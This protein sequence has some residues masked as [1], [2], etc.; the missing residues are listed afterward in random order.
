MAGVDRDPNKAESLNYRQHIQ[1][2]AQNDAN[3]VIEKDKQYG[4]SWCRRGGTGAYH[5]FIRKFDR[6]EEFVKKFDYDIFKAIV[7]DSRPE[8]IIDDIRDIRGYLLL[9]EAYAIEN[10][11]V[12]A[13]FQPAEQKCEARMNGFM[14]QKPRGHSGYH[15][16]GTLATDITWPDI[17]EERHGRNVP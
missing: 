16:S 6:L 14:C 10:E 5:V 12:A 8:G 15:S 1:P 3:V 2:L 11:L 13:R 9:I 17:F 4:A 7:M